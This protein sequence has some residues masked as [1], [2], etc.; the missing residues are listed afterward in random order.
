MPFNISQLQESQMYA[1]AIGLIM[2]MIWEQVNPFYLFF[3]TNKKKG[4]HFFKNLLLGGVNAVVISGLFVSLWAWASQ[5]SFQQQI[6]LLHLLPLGTFAHSVFAIMLFDFWM[7]V[8]HRINHIIPFFWRFHRVHHSDPSMDVTTASRFH[9]GEIVLSSAFR[10]PVIII[11][12]VHLGELLLYET[13]AFAVVQLHHANITLSSRVDKLL[14]MLIISPY[15]H[16]IHHSDWQPE[17]DSNYG[18]LF[19]F[20]DRMG[21]SFRMR[22]E[23]GFHNLTIGL[24][25]FADER[26]ETVKNLFKLP[27]FSI[28]NPELEE[29]QLS[30]EK[31]QKKT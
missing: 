15:M 11:L 28:K 27:L 2:L 1:Y 18:S 10:I 5:W 4:L 7:Y 20:W 16:K 14:R 30:S 23:E 29:T 12:G 25:E 13:I 6:G 22:S 26:Y 9:I 8:W 31:Q 21:R 17:T 3:R 24:K 19:S